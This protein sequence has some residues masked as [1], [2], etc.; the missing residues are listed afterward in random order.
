MTTSNLQVRRATVEDLPQVTPLWQQ[1]ALPC[2]DLEKRF[3][4][5]QVVVNEEGQLLGAI[6]LKVTGCEGLLH[7]EAFVHPE[8][9]D[10]LRQRLWERI[11]TVAQNHGLVRVWTQLEAPYW[12]QIELQ[13]APPELQVPADFGG[14]TSKWLYV[15]LREEKANPVNIE[16]EFALFREAEK[17]ATER[18]F[19]RARVLKM[20]AGVVGVVVFLLVVIWAFLF[21]KTQG[22]LPHGR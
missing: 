1:E 3:K 2:E 4:E 8:Q 11:K 13:A 19:R 7:S 18:L 16:K 9:A 10:L 22:K 15:Q 14:A 12:R 5:F 20:V 17:E 21:M 6:G